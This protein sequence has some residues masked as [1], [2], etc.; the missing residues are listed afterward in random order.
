MRRREF[1]VGSVAALVAIRGGSILAHGTPQAA[2]AALGNLGYPESVFTF[3]EAGFEIPSDIQAGVLQVT[4]DNQAAFP[5]GFSLIQLPEGA[6]MADLAPPAGATPSPDAGMPPVLYDATWA[7]GVF[8]MPASRSSVI[9]KLGPGEWILDAGPDSGLEPSVFSVAGE[10]SSD[11]IPSDGATVVELDNFQIRL[12]KTVPAGAGL[13]HVSNVGDQ[14]HEVFIAS[15]PVRLS[16]EDI[17]TLLML[18]EDATPPAGLPSFEEIQ[19]VAVVPPLSIGQ[20]ILFEMSLAPGHYLGACF[21]PDRTEGMPHAMEGM[22]V[23]F[24]IG[25]EGETV[26][27]PSSP[28]PMDHM[29]TFRPGLRLA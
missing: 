7:G 22:V 28:V 5:V 16:P 2:S 1:V 27:P 4:L 10:A 12:P 26:E 8:A 20:A 21:I 17:T 6:S 3:T 19:Q 23:S 14:P 9:L 24:S 13:W 29:R 15:T 25:A 11:E 18:P